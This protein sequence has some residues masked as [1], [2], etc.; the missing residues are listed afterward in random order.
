[1]RGK[2][3]RRRRNSRIFELLQLSLSLSD[4]RA[5]LHGECPKQSVENKLGWKCKLQ[6]A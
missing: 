2:K 3:R 4:A 6:K 5:C 1:M